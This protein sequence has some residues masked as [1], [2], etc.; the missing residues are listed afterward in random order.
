MYDRRLP[1]LKKAME[2]SPYRPF[3]AGFPSGKEPTKE[4]IMRKLSSL[5]RRPTLLKDPAL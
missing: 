5:P 2:L 4:A 1:L 3:G